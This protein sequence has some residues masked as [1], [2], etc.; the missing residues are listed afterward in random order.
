MLLV[1]MFMMLRLMEIMVLR[2]VRHNNNG[3]MVHGITV[4]HGMLTFVSVMRSLQSF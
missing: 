1:M 2:M 3:H 4:G